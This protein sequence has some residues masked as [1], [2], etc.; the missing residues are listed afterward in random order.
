MKEG[1][2]HLDPTAEIS[3]DTVKK[4]AV[5]GVVILTGRT[6]LLNVIT[7][8][9]QGFLWSFL[10]KYQF[11]VFWIVSAIV[12]FL[13]F[14]SDIGLAG[15]IIQKKEQVTSEDLKTTFL[16]QETLVIILLVA[17]AVLSPFLAKTY[18]LSRD[19]T[20]LLYALGISFFLSSLKSIPSV[21]LERKLE[22]VKFAVPQIIET[23]V[24][25][26]ALVFLA[27]KGFGIASFTYSVLIRGIIGVIVIYVLQPW[28]PGIA[29][30]FSSLKG[31]LKFGIPYQANTLLATL[32]DDG[33]VVILGGI[34]GP[35]GIGILGTA[36][37]LAQY[38][39]RFFMDHVT[40][41]TFPAFSRMQQERVSLTRAVNRSIFFICFLVMPSLVGIIVLM[42]LI[43]RVLPGYSK[44]EEALTPL[45][46]ISV[47]IFFASITTQL[48]NTLNAI[49][50]IKITFFLMV[51]WTILSYLFIP[52][53]GLKFGVNGAALGYSLVGASSIVAIIVAKN[54]IDFSLVDSALKPFLVSLAM[55]AI[56][57]VLRSILPTSFYSIWILVVTGAVSYVAMMLLLLGVSLV[58]DVKKSFST[59]FSK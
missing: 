37:K 11:G 42:P 32:K 36:Q 26:I 31:L 44:W 19:G 22:F 41:V 25:N 17:L 34:L 48:T 6:F 7:L 2:E 55:G 46:F 54:Y 28:K 9:A 16:V 5:K 59:F 50:K 1:E 53:M 29:F 14:F 38:P 49:G 3:L 12:N 58:E 56:L 4:R 35:A 18:S 24:Y 21:L 39:L 30:S 8:I 23:F 40:K 57:I 47:N 52:I 51:M 15:A 33:M 20:V 27:W 10:D 45:L 13:S 43:I